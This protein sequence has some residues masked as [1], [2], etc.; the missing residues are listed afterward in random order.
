M[1][2]ALPGQRTILR[3][4]KSQY[5]LTIAPKLWYEHLRKALDDM[6]FKASSY[7][8]CLL[9]QKGMI[10]VTYVDDCGLGVDDP[11][12]IDWFVSELRKRGF[13]LEVEGDFTAF[14]GVAIDRTEDGRIHMHQTALIDKII[15]TAEMQDCNPN[16]TPA[17]TTALGSDENGEPW[18]QYPWK[19]SSIVGMMVYLSTNTRPDI[20]YAVSSVGRFNRCPKKSHASAVKTIIRYLKGTRDKGIYIEISNKLNLETY[21]DADFCGLFGS[22][23]ARDRNSAR[24]RGG[25]IISFGGVPLIWKSFLISRICLS[26]LESEYCTLSKT[27]VQ[28]IAL[29]NLIREILDGLLL[30]QGATSTLSSCVFEDNNGALL[31]ATKQRIT[32]RTKYFLSSWHHFWSHVSTNGGEDGKTVIMKISTD[33]QRADYLSKGLSRELFENNRRLNQGW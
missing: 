3:L 8:P 22:E 31:L 7:D 9:F 27:M 17:A 16:Y 29:E 14:L 13:E 10:L 32:S 20:A 21:C 1:M 12:K 19:Y 5:G 6:G 26:T 11:K 15:K 18:A 2:E 23:N 24:S 28:V 30:N 25:Y 33:K 4:R